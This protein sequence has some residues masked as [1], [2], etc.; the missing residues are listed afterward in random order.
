MP[1]DAGCPEKAEGSRGE[2]QWGGHCGSGEPGELPG[3]G[4]RASVQGR[5]GAAGWA[6]VL[7]PDSPAIGACGPADAGAEA[8]QPAVWRP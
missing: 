1:D 7:T 8:E 2:G 5:P 6:R 3:A 4:A